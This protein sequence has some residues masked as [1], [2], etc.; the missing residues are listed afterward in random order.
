MIVTKGSKKYP[1][2]K[3]SFRKSDEAKNNK[4]N[5]VLPIDYYDDF[6]VNDDLYIYTP[7]GTLLVNTYVVNKTLNITSS[8][9]QLTI[10]A[11][12]KESLM[13]N[14]NWS[15]V[16]T[17]TEAPLIIGSVISKVT[18]DIKGV[19]LTRVNVKFVGY[20]RTDGIQVTK[21]N[22]PEIEFTIEDMEANTA[23]YQAYTSLGASE[24]FQTLSSF[25]GN[26]KPIYE[27]VRELSQPKNTGIEKNFIWYLDEDNYFRWYQVDG[28]V[29]ASKYLYID[30]QLTKKQDDKVNFIIAYLGDDLNGN[31][32]YIYSYKEYS[33]T[34]NIQESIK[35]WADIARDLRDQYT[36]NTA[37]RE[38]VKEKGLARARAYFETETLGRITGSFTVP[39]YDYRIG[40]TLKISHAYGSDSYK[41]IIKALSLTYD[42]K[43]GPRYTYEFEEIIE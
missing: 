27:W 24:K 1:P 41:V 36:D 30:Y 12:D 4:V 39:T 5:I 23:A 34:P 38:A 18:A 19:N 31:P 28:T 20:P 16:F 9:P 11:F 33:G 15:E 2:L 32:I 22:H 7:D 29:D 26:F 14:R 6:D 3:L 35:D 43:K 40:Q 8:T 13:F 10:S 37:F 17:N 21:T 42:M 25:G